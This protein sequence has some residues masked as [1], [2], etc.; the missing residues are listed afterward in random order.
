MVYSSGGCSFFFK[1]LNSL[2]LNN[3]LVS[4]TRH[5]LFFVEWIL[6]FLRNL[7]FEQGKCAILY[8][9][10]SRGMLFVA[11]PRHPCRVGLGVVSLWEL[12]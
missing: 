4:S 7:G 1:I 9:Y 6:S 3:W 8:T 5:N 10:S 2:A 12:K 11:V